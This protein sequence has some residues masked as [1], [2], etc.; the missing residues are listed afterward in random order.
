MMDFLIRRIFS[1]LATLWA[2]SLVIFLVLEVL[3]GDV[4]DVLLG[5][6]ARSD[7]INALRVQLGLDRPA[8]ERYFD[9][10]GSLITGGTRLS[11]TY[12][13]PVG[14]LISERL[15]VTL[16]IALLAFFM[17]SAV[18][19]PLG[20][21]AARN[22]GKAGD[23]IV[24]GFSQ[25]GLA[26]PGFWLAII[27]ILV[28][29]VG[30]G[31]VPA[32]GFPGWKAGLGTALQS[33]LLPA[34]ALGMA[35]AAILA[36]VTRSAMLDAMAED[37]VRTARAKGLNE[38]AVLRRHVLRN[39][40]IPILTIMGLQFAFLLAGSVVIENVFH[41]PGLGRLLLQA[42]FQ[43]DVIVVQDV[44]LLVCGLVILVN[45]IVDIAYVLIDPRPRRQA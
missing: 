45:L 43:R 38:W 36:R 5:T 41:I 18:A 13:V 17:S 8:M 39:A 33:L 25:A 16:P 7:T 3:P 19:I 42:I 30:L 14:D 23:F 10:V 31:W 32:G 6:S 35:E 44:V 9:W 29:A 24:M 37:Y 11:H 26:V 4:A 12:G 15:A 2:A 22:R 28:F 27:L 21:H 1:S 34:I 20:I 40:A